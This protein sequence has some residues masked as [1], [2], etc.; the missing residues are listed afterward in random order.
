MRPLCRWWST[1]SRPTA[2][3]CAGVLALAFAPL[4]SAAQ[5][6][7]V[8]RG[9][10]AYQEG[11]WDSAV[12]AYEA[13]VASGH[14]SGGLEYNLGNAYFKAGDLGRAILH[15]E[16]AL[17]LSPG[18]PD[19]LA[20]L[21]LARSLTVD[22]VEPLPR[23]WLTSAASWWVDLLSRRGLLTVAALGW[24]ALTGGMFVRIV[25][26]SPATRAVAGWTSAAG[27]VILLLFA[28]ALVVR[29]AGV[30]VPERAVILADAASVHSAPAAD[31]DLTLFEVHEG[32]LVRVDQRVG[33]WVEVVLED[34]KV[35]WVPAEILE[36]I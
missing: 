30:G 18:D 16:R 12:E 9:N 4:G 34:G 1:A 5:D 33:D 24:M 35:G 3:V 6:E 21:D 13:V 23:F 36:V 7:I 26:R 2:L 25:A 10:Q 29:E 15:W 11:D 14:R 19:V 22:A 31:A 27:A 28:P 32:T 17:E 8:A 20:N